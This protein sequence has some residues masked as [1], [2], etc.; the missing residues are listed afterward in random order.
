MP[1]N[2]H[3]YKVISTKIL[4]FSLV[5][6]KLMELKIL[7]LVFSLAE[8]QI[9][10]VYGYSGDN[11]FYFS[12]KTYIMSLHLNLVSF[13]LPRQDGS[14]EWSQHRLNGEL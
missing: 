2:S 14:K 8:H 11:V 3:V 5:K 9:R 12:T 10:W 7:N 1:L 4:A 13:E 6:A